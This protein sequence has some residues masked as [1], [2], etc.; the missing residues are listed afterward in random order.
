M[1]SQ[2][3]KILAR[4]LAEGR[5]IEKIP[6]TDE[7]IEHWTKILEEIRRDSIYKQAM[8]ERDA[9]KIILTS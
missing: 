3:D 1:I 8:S 5:K 7:Q 9:S 2:T 4:L 6:F